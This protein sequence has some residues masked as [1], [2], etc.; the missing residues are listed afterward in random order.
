M[1][2]GFRIILPVEVR[3]PGLSHQSD[4]SEARCTGRA[5]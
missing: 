1:R 5:P 4:I 3:P 2:C